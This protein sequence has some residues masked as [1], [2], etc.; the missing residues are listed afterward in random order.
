MTNDEHTANDGATA[1]AVHT[2]LLL[3]CLFAN[4]TQVHFHPLEYRL[5]LKERPGPNRDTSTRD[6][7]VHT[8]YGLLDSEMFHIFICES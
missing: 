1:F 7:G 2:R 4:K 8:V 6:L 3:I 5:K